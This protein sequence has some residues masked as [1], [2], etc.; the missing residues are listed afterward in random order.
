MMDG[1][2]FAC[3]F[4]FLFYESGHCQ[5][6]P[7][8]V[9][10]LHLVLEMIV[11]VT[12]ILKRNLTINVRITTESCGRK[13]VV[14]SMHSLSLSPTSTVLLCCRLSSSRFVF[15]FFFSFLDGSECF[16]IFCR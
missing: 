8:C 2:A 14:G 16:H 1:N 3:L 9:F 5:F 11:S 7:L 4:V 13:V 10:R 6:Q 12:R 15:F